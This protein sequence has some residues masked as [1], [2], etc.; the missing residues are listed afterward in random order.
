MRDIVALRLGADEYP[1]H[2]DADSV[3]A[4]RES[5]DEDDDGLTAS[6]SIDFAKR[7]I[8]LAPDCLCNPMN[9]LQILFHEAGHVIDIAL[10]MDLT[11]AQVDAMAFA[12]RSLMVQ[13]GFLCPEDY[14]VAGVALRRKR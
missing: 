14:K 1:I 8:C 4:I 3:E 6:G 12:W 10:G 9:A 5:I 11:E 2:W 13:S 7:E